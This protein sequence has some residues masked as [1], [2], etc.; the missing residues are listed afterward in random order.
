[1]NEVSHNIQLDTLERL[2][3]VNY[4][5]TGILD[6]FL[7]V[8]NTHRDYDLFAG[9]SF[10]S[11]VDMWFGFAVTTDD[12]LNLFN[13]LVLKAWKCFLNFQSFLSYI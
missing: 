7:Y 4:M 2:I 8:F 9:G 3:N 13:F 1:M 12:L 5:C 10:G 11:H 6:E